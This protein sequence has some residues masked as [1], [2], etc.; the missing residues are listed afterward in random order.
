MPNWNYNSVTI[1]APRDAVI[2]RLVPTKD[3][4]FEFNM[5]KLFPEM[6]AEDLKREQ[7]ASAD[8]MSVLLTH[9][10]EVIRNNL[11]QLLS[12]KDMKAL[13]DRQDPEY[14]KLADEI[15]TSHIS[16]PGLQAVLKLLLAEDLTPEDLRKEAKNSL[17]RLHG[18]LLKNEQDV[19]LFER[20]A[21]M[22]RGQR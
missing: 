20:L 11:P 16:Y 19:Q 15:C 4:T 17:P 14:K 8:N 22:S 2:E 12:Y 18:A 3:Q 10:S 5:H 6:F 21:F 13:L 1:N 9:L 7:L